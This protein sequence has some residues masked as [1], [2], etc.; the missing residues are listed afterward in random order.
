MSIIYTNYN[1]YDYTSLMIRKLKI[2]VEKLKKLLT[3][4]AYLDRIMYKTKNQHRRGIYYKRA[5]E[6]RRQ[7]RHFLIKAYE[8]IKLFIEM[9]SFEKNSK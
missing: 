6:F 7:A 2:C 4:K 9:E 1:K 5:Q 8:L 3:E